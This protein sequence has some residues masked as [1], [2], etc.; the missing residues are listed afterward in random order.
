MSDTQTEMSIAPRGYERERTS[1][2]TLE[3]SHNR[4]ADLNRAKRIQQAALR[5]DTEDARVQAAA[6]L[7]SIEDDLGAIESELQRLARAA[8]VTLQLAA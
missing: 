5:S 8:G 4:W 1:A 6:I 2:E 7:D 3:A